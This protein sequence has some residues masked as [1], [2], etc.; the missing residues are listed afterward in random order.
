MTVIVSGRQ[1]ENDPIRRRH[2]HLSGFEDDRDCGICYPIYGT[3]VTPAPFLPL[4][5][6]E[7]P[8]L[9]DDLSEY[10]HDEVTWPRPKYLG[11]D[12]EFRGWTSP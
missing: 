3:A 7:P 11:Q 4:A 9:T 8:A 10:W 6:P 5:A 12:Y 1:Y 2:T